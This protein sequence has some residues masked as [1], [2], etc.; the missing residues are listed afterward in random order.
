MILDDD[1]VESSAGYYGTPAKDKTTAHLYADEDFKKFSVSEKVKSK[2]HYLDSV[3]KSA[4]KDKN[5]DL[6]KKNKGLDKKNPSPIIKNLSNKES[7]ALKGVLQNPPPLYT[8]PP[9]NRSPPNLV[10]K[11]PHQP[12]LVRKNPPQPNFVPMNPPLKSA[13]QNPPPK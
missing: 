3:K 9:K 6:D 13:P 5:I 8:S 12:N 10:P 7:P 2:S 1:K 4:D 11:N